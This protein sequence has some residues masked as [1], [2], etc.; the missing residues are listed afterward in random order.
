MSNNVKWL[1]DVLHEWLDAMK[2]GGETNDLIQKFCKE[3]EFKAN[4]GA[5]YIVLYVIPDSISDFRSYRTL[6]VSVVWPI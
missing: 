1:T 6:N 2:T 3:D 5:L 4:V